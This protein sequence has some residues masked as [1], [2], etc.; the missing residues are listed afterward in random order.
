MECERCLKGVRCL[1]AACRHLEIVAQQFTIH[2]MSTIVND[3]MSALYGVESAE[4]GNALVGNNYVDRVLGVVDVRHHRYDVRD[5]T[6]LGDGGT[7]ED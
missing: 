5:F 2:G 3:D 6:L 4:V 7:R 1:T